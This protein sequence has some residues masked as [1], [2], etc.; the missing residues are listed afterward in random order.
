MNIS[1]SL[2]AVMLLC[3]GSALAQAPNQPGHES[4]RP[5]TN[6]EA[7]SA[8][9]DAIAGL[10]GR[11]S[12]EMTGSVQGFVTAVATSDMY[13]VEAG[14]LASQRARNPEIKAFAN[15]MVEAHTKAS[16]AL[17][18]SGPNH[19]REP[20]SA[21]ISPSSGLSHAPRS[22]RAA[23]TWLNICERAA[24]NSMERLSRST[25]RPANIARAWARL[26]P[27]RPNRCSP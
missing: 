19:D 20:A 11:I 7:I 12:A 13:E 1:K 8:T 18:G 15:M 14:K 5:G 6:T 24:D 27:S 2:L 16:T 3:T 4:P 26:P 17:K 9:E 21:H 10:V 22:I 25:R 23:S